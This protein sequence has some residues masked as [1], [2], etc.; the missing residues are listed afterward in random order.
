MG[1]AAGASLLVPR[2]EYLASSTLLPVPCFYYLADSASGNRSCRYCRGDSASLVPR[3]SCPPIEVLPPYF[4][5][6][7]S[8]SHF[9]HAARAAMHSGRS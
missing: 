2:F 5:Q 4:F 6:G 7:W 3:K 8:F 1:R 9:C